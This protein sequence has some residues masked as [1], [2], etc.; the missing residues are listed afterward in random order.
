MKDYP[1]AID[2]PK[3]KGFFGIGI[4]SGM[5]TQNIGTIWRSAQIMGAAFIFVIGVSIK[6]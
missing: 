1:N 2:Y 5:Q 4:E 3:T 6:E